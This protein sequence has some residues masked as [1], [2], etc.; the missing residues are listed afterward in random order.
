MEISYE[1]LVSVIDDYIAGIYEYDG[2]VYD[3]AEVMELVASNKGDFC[4][5]QNR[6]HG[7]KR[8]CNKVRI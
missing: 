1:G 5:F 6:K 2:K 4:E 3:L 8:F 7:K